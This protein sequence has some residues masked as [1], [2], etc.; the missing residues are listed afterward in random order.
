MFQVS[1]WNGD[2]LQSPF[3]PPNRALHTQCVVRARFSISKAANTLHR[4]CN[5]R[6]PLTI[7]RLAAPMW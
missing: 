6:A 4:Y 2:S 1:Q 3:H 5:N 7:I